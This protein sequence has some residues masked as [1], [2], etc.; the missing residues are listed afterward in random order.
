MASHS[1]L[2]GGRSRTPASPARPFLG[3]TVAPSKMVGPTICQTPLQSG[4]VAA[5]CCAYP[6][7]AANKKTEINANCIF[8]LSI[9]EITLLRLNSFNGIESYPRKFPK[10][11]QKDSGT[12]VTPNCRRRGFPHQPEKVE[13]DTITSPVHSSP[14]CYG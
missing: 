8:I 9:I 6:V 10:S 13:G 2:Y 7:T 11:I 14:I 3:S 1:A 5:C 12:G 4:S